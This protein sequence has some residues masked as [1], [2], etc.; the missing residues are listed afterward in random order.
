MRNSDCLL[1]GGGDIAARK[2]SLL[3]QAQAKMTDISPMVSGA[4]TVLTDDGSGNWVPA[5]F[6]NDIETA[7]RL[8]IAATD[9]GIINQQ[10]YQYVKA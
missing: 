7:Y 1:V 4:M 6:S 2:A 5:I 9:D 3:C 8:A 10:V